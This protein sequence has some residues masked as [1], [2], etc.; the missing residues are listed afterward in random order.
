M[1]ADTSANRQEAT[2][3]L[4]FKVRILLS[5][6]CYDFDI[7]SASSL[8]IDHRRTVFVLPARPCCASEMEEHFFLGIQE[9]IHIHD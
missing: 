7:T 4:I 8:Q 6:I 2:W 9:R 3:T 1:G 5:K